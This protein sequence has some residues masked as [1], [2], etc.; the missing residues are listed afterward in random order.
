VVVGVVLAVLYHYASVRTTSFL[1]GKGKTAFPMLSVVGFLVRLTVLGAVF[2]VMAMW[3]KPHLDIIAT[4]LAFITAFT[5]F[6]GFSL[7]RFA[8]GGRKQGTST[9]AIL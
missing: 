4:A 5:V 9:R 7:Y 1:A 2:V 6:T 8:V 3:L